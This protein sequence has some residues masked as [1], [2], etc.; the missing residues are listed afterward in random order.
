MPSPVDKGKGKEVDP[1]G[2]QK[3][4][5]GEEGTM[6][7]KGVWEGSKEAR[8]RGLRERKER[9]ILEAR[10][11]VPVFS[12]DTDGVYLYSAGSQRC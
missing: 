9:M 4:G 12:S 6:G 2:T 1:M 10:R 5:S 11:W 7:E 3:S 8:E